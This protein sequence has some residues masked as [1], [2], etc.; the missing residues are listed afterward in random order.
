LTKYLKIP[1][2]DDNPGGLEHLNRL[3]IISPLIRKAITWQKNSTR[4]RIIQIF[5]P[6]VRDIETRLDYEKRY[7]NKQL[8]YDFT[9]QP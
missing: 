9:D 5:L 7:E 6:H 4:C 3:Q 1:G 8:W 2:T